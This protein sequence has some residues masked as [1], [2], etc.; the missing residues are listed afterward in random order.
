MEPTETQKYLELVSYQN[1][2]TDLAN[3]T[4]R[5]I[6]TMFWMVFINNHLLL[7]V[8]GG[9]MVRDGR[10][11]AAELYTLAGLVNESS[12]KI[13]EIINNFQKVHTRAYL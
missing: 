9:A 6:G 7:E 3:N 5:V 8:A 12:Y 2:L 1:N 10:I 4:T 11:G 13:Y